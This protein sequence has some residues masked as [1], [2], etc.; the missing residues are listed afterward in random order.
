[1]KKI[2]IP[3]VVAVVV[4]LG[5]F[6]WTRNTPVD[7]PEATISAIPDI[8]PAISQTPTHSPI[9]SNQ[10]PAVSPIKA[11]APVTHNI[12]IQNFAFSQKSI[13]LKKEDMVMWTN[14]DSAPH[15][16]TG[17]SGGLSSPTLNANGTYSFTFNNTGTF[18]YHCA[19]HPSMTGTIIVIQ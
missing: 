8:R 12:T 15:T 11:P 14:K 1:M 4:G 3:I 16:V 18:N 17:E 19:F 5:Y 9:P 6:I 2:I 13:T 10:A 7:K